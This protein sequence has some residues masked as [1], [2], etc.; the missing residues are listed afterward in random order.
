LVVVASAA[1]IGFVWYTLTTVVRGRFATPTVG[2]ENLLGRRCVAVDDLD[3]IGVVLLDGS[4]W[5]A[6]ADRGVTI[7]PGAPVEV[8]GITGLLLEVD[9]IGSKSTPAPS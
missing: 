9:P 7:T 8:V 1:S 6:T 3:P 4:R 2:R 5:R